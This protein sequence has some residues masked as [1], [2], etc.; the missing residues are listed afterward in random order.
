MK[1]NIQIT[2]ASLPDYP[3]IQNMARFYVYDLSRQCGFISADWT[4]PADGL[5]ACFDLLSYF[6]ETTRRAYLIRVN[7]E[8]AGFVLLNQKGSCVINADWNMNE[9]FILAKFQ[10]KGVGSFVA[11]AI[12]D[13]HPGLWEITVIPENR[14]AFVFWQKTIAAYMHDKYR[15]EKKHV[16][17]NQAQPYRMVFTFDTKLK[18]QESQLATTL[19]YVIDYDPKAED[20]AVIRQGIIHFNKQVIQ[21]TAKHW[22][23]YVKD[24]QQRIIGGA[25]I[26]EHSDALY[27][28]VLWVAMAYRK[29]GIGLKLLQKIEN[30][31]RNKSI[32]KLY[33]DTYTFQSQGFYEKHGFYPIATIKDYLLGFDRIYMRKELRV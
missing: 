12:F 25:L 22:S 21:E 26:W 11:H 24:Q 29:Q 1:Q 13:Q 4:I 30:A 8:L 2:S 27:I 17:P 15:C 20:D 31:P 33:V 9:F 19:T 32:S 18:T 6:K 28:D 5:Y 10:G 23:I 14:S 3:V 7:D 16:R